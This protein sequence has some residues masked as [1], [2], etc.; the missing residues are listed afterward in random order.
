MRTNPP[1]GI[2]APFGLAY[3]YYSNQTPPA[4]LEVRLGKF[5]RS[6]PQV[7][8]SCEGHAWLT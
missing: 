1:G 8:L 3:H 7:M 2:A 6:H 4:W 5:Q